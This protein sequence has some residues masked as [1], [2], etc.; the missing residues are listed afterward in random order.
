MALA[1]AIL[2]LILILGNT[3]WPRIKRFLASDDPD[4]IQALADSIAIQ[5]TESFNLSDSSYTDSLLNQVVEV[6]GD[7]VIRRIRQ[8]WPRYLPFEF[9]VERLRELSRDRG[10]I[11]DC[12]ESGEE[13]H[14]FCTIGSPVFVGTQV[15]VEPRR[16]TKLSGREI[17]FVFRNLGALSDQKIMQI[18]DHDIAFSYFASPD[19]YPSRRIRKALEKTGVVSI[20]EL[21]TDIWSLPEFGSEDGR[22]PSKNRP[23]RENI[24]YQELAKS[25][26]KRHPNPGAI[27][28]KR[29]D[30]N[31][32]AFV[33][34]TIEFAAAT[35]AAYFYK[36]DT[37]DGIDSLAYSS[38]LIMISMKSV[39]DFR[40]SAVGEIAPLVLHD[41][42]S[43][44]IPSR[45]IVLLDASILDVKAFIDLH[46]TL[47][48]LGINVL[49]C[50]SLADVRESL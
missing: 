4:R 6:G 34:S 42:I 5:T 20:I 10:L 16:G 31:D 26:F 50:I 2:L 18:L 39:A 21:P 25:L 46:K 32:S 15:I 44:P 49:S 30:A 7:H 37:P 9:Y 43:S 17:A 35:K 1:L 22:P 45:N 12:V 29:S 24:D 3:Q 47:R 40:N 28:F 27:F 14:L 48:D 13:K 41:L 36:N 38:G 33:R 19:V 11:C 23:D 8:P